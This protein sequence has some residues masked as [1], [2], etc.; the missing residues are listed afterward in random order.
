MYTIN[1]HI[2]SCPKQR[3]LIVK[4]DLETELVKIVKVTCYNYDFVLTC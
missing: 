4:N 3:H 2:V 1:Y